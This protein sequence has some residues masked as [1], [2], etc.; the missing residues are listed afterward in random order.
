M[1]S[2]MCIRD[3]IDTDVNGIPD[4]CDN[5]TDDSSQTDKLHSQT[6]DFSELSYVIGGLMLII[7]VIYLRKTQA[8]NS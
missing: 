5:V 8:D 7:L 6:N 2:E 1:G 3:R 4:D